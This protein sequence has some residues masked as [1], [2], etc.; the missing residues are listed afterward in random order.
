MNSNLASA[1]SGYYSRRAEA[2]QGQL[3]LVVDPR[4]IEAARSANVRRHFG[5]WSSAQPAH[6]IEALNGVD[7]RRL[8]VVSA[9]SGH[10]GVMAHWGNA[11]DRLRCTDSL[12]PAL[13]ATFSIVEL[14]RRA[15]EARASYPHI[16]DRSGYSESVDRG[17]PS[18]RF[19]FCVGSESKR[20]CCICVATAVQKSNRL[21]DRA[22]R[23]FSCSSRAI[24]HAAASPCRSE[25]AS[26]ARSE[27]DSVRRNLNFEPQSPQMVPVGAAKSL[28]RRTWGHF[29]RLAPMAHRLLDQVAQAHLGVDPAIYR[30]KTRPFIPEGRPCRFQPQRDRLR[31][32]PPCRWRRGRT[33]RSRTAMCYV[34]R[35]SATRRSLTVKGRAHHGW[36]RQSVEGGTSDRVRTFCG[37]DKNVDRASRFVIDD[38]AQGGLASDGEPFGW[39]CEITADVVD[40]DN[41]SVTLQGQIPQGSA[42][43]A[44][45]SKYN[46][47]ISRP[48]YKDQMI[49]SVS[50][51]DVGKL[52]E[53]A[54][55]FTAIVKPPARYPVPSYNYA[56]PRAANALE[57][58]HRVLAGYFASNP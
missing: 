2:P 27:N 46:H 23:A 57:R 38:R 17:A 5:T 56:C 58:L 51:A 33:C 37:Q 19:E 35:W 54:A 20:T 25:R 30:R 32:E 52:Q 55:A 31:R 36:E 3:V 45:M 34:G 44:W 10:A 28:S 11:A 18:A 13:P 26:P 16:R 24:L 43:R 7:E 48:S 4:S 47:Q 40:N 9:T 42:V 41:L 39:F 6:M 50:G 14:F 15:Q 49:F 12:P 8:R 22:R 21:R 29:N 53:L 1:G